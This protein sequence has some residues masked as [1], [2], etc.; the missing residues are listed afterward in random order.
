MTC[1]SPI[2]AERLPTGEVKL[3]RHDVG[4]VF[5]QKLKAARRYLR[6]PC[7]QCLGC[8]L[9]YSREWA[10]R[11]VNEAQTHSKSSFL[12][13]TYRDADLPENGSLDRSD[14]TKFLK[15]LRKKFNV[16]YYACGEYGDK[17]GRPHYHV[18]LFG[19]DFSDD[20]TQIGNPGGQ[21]LYT[22]ETLE[23]IWGKGHV[24]I[25][26]FN[27]T[28]AAYVARY[29]TK[30]ING[31]QKDKHYQ[32]VDNETG[33]V[34]EL[35]QEFAAMSLKPGIGAEWLN[36]YMSDV[37]PSSEIIHDGRAHPVPRYYLDILKKQDPDMYA[38]VSK[39]RRSYADQ[40]AE[41]HT[42]E[43]LIQKERVAKQNMLNF[44]SRRMEQSQ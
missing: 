25:G 12:T 9:K 5:R 30:K 43:R 37:F 8:R 10:L 17:L 3:H 16:R 44:M 24:S 19:E 18:V 26:A 28:T 35:K 4:E 1:Y 11:C 20:R 2:E 22:S 36:T 29:V 14:L 21:P 31:A 32:R 39:E 34:Y 42:Y 27:F 6:L 23:S 40:Q 7:G 38:R 15:R 41:L 13:L 33:E